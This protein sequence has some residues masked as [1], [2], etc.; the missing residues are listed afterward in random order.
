MLSGQ[1]IFTLLACAG[2]SYTVAA[3]SC[4]LHPQGGRAEVELHLHPLMVASHG[5]AVW[6]FL[7]AARNHPSPPRIMARTE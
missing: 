4:D 3:S 1:I 6:K 2:M 7:C 5:C